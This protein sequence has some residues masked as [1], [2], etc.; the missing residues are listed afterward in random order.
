MNKYDRSQDC[1]GLRGDL[2]SWGTMNRDYTDVFFLNMAPNH[3]S[4]K[5]DRSKPLILMS[6]RSLL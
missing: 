2:G 5:K 4:E 6:L 1:V 3:G